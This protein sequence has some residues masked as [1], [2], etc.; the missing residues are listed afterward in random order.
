M[1]TIRTHDRRRCP[2][3]TASGHITARTL[4]EGQGRNT[5]QVEEVARALAD[6]GTAGSGEA[7]GT[8]ES[9]AGARYQTLCLS[10]AQHAAATTNRDLGRAAQDENGQTVRPCIPTCTTER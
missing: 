7:T 1:K 6:Q 8:S 5:N 4:P 10:R 3:R 2:W 9:L